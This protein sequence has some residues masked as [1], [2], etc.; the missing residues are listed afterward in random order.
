MMASSSSLPLIILDETGKLVAASPD[1]KGLN[2]G[3]ASEVLSAPKAWTVPT[4]VG[5][6]LFIRDQAEIVALQ[7]QA[8]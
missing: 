8:K 3:D 6:N 2:K 7:I 5:N 1:S 4:L